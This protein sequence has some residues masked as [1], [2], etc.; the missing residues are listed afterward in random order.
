MANFNA[1][2][3]T[4]AVA[5]PAVNNK[6]NKQHGRIRIFE[7]TMTVP[8]GGIAIADTITWGAL[9]AGARTFGN[10]G[11]LYFG[12]GTVAS[13]INVGD[14]ASAARHLAA[15]AVD[16]AGS[17]IPEA[18]NASGTA[19]ETS[20]ASGGA[21]DNCTLKSVVAGAALLAGQVITLRMPFALD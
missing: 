10:M 21:T 17:A 15:T 12:A 6:A 13:T 16:A 5:K 11:K 3:A 9:P 4:N 20:D 19:F 7:S 8:T 1:D 14:A 18:A 2:N